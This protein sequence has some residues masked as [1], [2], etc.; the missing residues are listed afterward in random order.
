[1]RGGGPIR[2]AAKCRND[3]LGNFALPR[4]AAH[5]FQEH[6][7]SEWQPRRS[8]KSIMVRQALEA[9]L[10]KGMKVAYG[11]SSGWLIMKRYGKLTSIIPMREKISIWEDEWI[12]PP[13]PKE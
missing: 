3:N 4:P 8:G 2:D 1:L 10:D 11:S 12:S 7:M 6:L 5:F 13:S 9:A